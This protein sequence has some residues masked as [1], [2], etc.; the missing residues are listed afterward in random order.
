MNVIK[1]IGFNLCLSMALSPFNASAVVVNGGFETSLSSWS[2]TGDVMTEDGFYSGSGPTEG[3]SQAILTT[4]SDWGDFTPGLSFNDAVDTASMESFLGLSV[5]TLGSYDAYEGS[6]IMQ[7]FTASAGEILSF[8][9]NFLTDDG[10]NSGDTAFVIVDG[11]FTTLADASTS[12]LSSASGF[13]LEETGYNTFSFDIAESGSHTIA[14]GVFDTIDGSGAS[15][16]LVDNVN[17]VSVSV[18]EPS[19]L[20]LMLLGG[21]G[22]LLTQ[23]R[24]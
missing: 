21:F 20:A 18:P 17:L 6:A 12:L 5:G 16:L 11:I 22:L 10:G 9:W 15:G 7:T 8:D 1:L 19:T 3:S 14:F 13:F 4:M 24:C 23:K 2:S